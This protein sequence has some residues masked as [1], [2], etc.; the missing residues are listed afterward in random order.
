MIVHEES[1]FRFEFGTSWEF[2]E[3]WDKCTAYVYGIG[4]LSG[5][6]DGRS[7]STK[8]LDLVGLRDGEVWLFEIKDFR[9]RP[10][11]LKDRLDELPLEIALKVRDT[12]AGLLG[13]QCLD[14]AEDW[15]V[16]AVDSI[17]DDSVL[18]VVA[19]IAQPGGLPVEKR[20]IHDDV[21]MKRMRQRLAWITRRVYVVD[22]TD[23]GRVPDL[24]V[25]ALAQSKPAKK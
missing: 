15:V 20:K 25:T 5:T 2:V 8:A 13:R 17:V 22:P 21:L 3:C 18:T 7:E 6:V 24:T 11:Q 19:L 4:T 9:N 12:V 14:Q 23:A 1:A 10:I 16:D